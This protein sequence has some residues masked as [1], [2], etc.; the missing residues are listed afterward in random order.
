MLHLVQFPR[1]TSSRSLVPPFA[2]PSA[3]CSPTSSRALAERTKLL[4]DKLQVL[5][6][7]QPRTAIF[8][9]GIVE[10]YVDRALNA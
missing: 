6:L 10:R 8:L 9:L 5:V 2:S 7:T 4:I 1:P 3:T